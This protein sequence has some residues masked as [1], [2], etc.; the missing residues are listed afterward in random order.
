[1]GY[2]SYY[3]ILFLVGGDIVGTNLIHES[4]QIK[5]LQIRD[6]SGIDKFAGKEDIV[7]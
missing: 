1:M 6:R 5:T 2:I 7:T 4:N 3:F